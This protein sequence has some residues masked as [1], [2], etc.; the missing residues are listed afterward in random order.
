MEKW[1]VNT[2]IQFQKVYVSGVHDISIAQFHYKFIRPPPLER[3]LYLT[4]VNLYMLRGL[5]AEILFCDFLC[6]HDIFRRGLCCCIIQ[7][8]VCDAT[9]LFKNNRRT[10]Y[11]IFL[12]CYCSSKWCHKTL[13]LITK[14]TVV[15]S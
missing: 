3:L 2:I 10:L 14:W 4:F 11:Y 12:S 9:F 6:P 13:H 15:R 8:W 1:N 5:I 7:F